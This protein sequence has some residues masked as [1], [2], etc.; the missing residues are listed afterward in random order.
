MKRP[1]NSFH[2]SRVRRD[3]LQTH[4]VSVVVQRNRRRAAVTANR[5]QTDEPIPTVVQHAIARRTDRGLK[6]HFDQILAIELLQN[7]FGERARQTQPLRYRRSGR[8][9]NRGHVL[10]RELTKKPFAHAEIRQFFRNRRTHCFHFG[11]RQY[12]CLRHVVCRTDIPVCPLVLKL[13][14]MDRQECLSYRIYLP[15]SCCR[16]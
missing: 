3:R 14:N 4:H 15:R 13:F 12:G 16:S 8:L 6:P 5:Q 9:G 2:R 10:E 7:L 11:A 1:A